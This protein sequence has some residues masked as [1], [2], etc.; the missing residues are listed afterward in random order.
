MSKVP[1][2]D[3]LPTPGWTSEAEPRHVSH[4]IVPAP[5]RYKICAED[6]NGSE[7]VIDYE[8]YDKAEEA[9]QD[10]VS[11]VDNFRD[12]VEFDMPPYNVAKVSLLN[13]DGELIKA[14]VWG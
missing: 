7:Y 5:V 6:L 13:Y 2:G 14:A 12:L 8:T 4:A 9:F 3:W 1:F 11:R 10:C